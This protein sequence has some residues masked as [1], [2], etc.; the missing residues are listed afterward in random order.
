MGCKV[1]IV[2]AFSA[3]IHA[4]AVNLHDNGQGGQV[5]S[6]VDP[7]PCTPPRDIHADHL[8]QV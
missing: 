7:G 4:L 8:R 1:A 2:S 6:K 3:V 5:L